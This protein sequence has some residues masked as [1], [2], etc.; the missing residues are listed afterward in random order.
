MKFW[1][2]LSKLGKL[3]LPSVELQHTQHLLWQD[4]KIYT[5]K[6][7]TIVEDSG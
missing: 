6:T 5:W 2:I 1:N 4:Y 3:E 7:P